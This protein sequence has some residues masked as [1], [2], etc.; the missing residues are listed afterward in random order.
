MALRMSA[1]SWSSTC[2]SVNHK[3]SSTGSPR[4]R[5]S[6]SHHSTSVLAFC[7]SFFVSLPGLGS[8]LR[9][10]RAFWPC[11]KILLFLPFYPASCSFLFSSG[12]SLFGSFCATLVPFDFVS[13]VFRGLSCLGYFFRLGFCLFVAQ[14]TQCDYARWHNHRF[15]FV[16]CGFLFF[17]V[18][19]FLFVLLLLLL[20]VLFLLLV[21][22]LRPFRTDFVFRFCF[23]L[24]HLL[25]LHPLR[26]SNPLD[27]V[28]VCKQVF[29]VAHV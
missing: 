18:F 24:R 26:S 12:R 25:L 17:L 3:G 29:R 7:S 11:L 10:S 2:A 13:S 4:R 15:L 28:T 16:L 27:F 21:F 6:T 9:T 14:C 5:H 22:L 20:L 8:S 1:S 23:V 19:L